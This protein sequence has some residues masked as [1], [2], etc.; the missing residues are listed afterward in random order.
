MAVSGIILVLYLIAHMIG[1]L[2]AFQ[3]EETFNHYS[4]W[5]R[6]IGDPAAAGPTALV[7][8]PARPAGRRVR[9]HVGRVLAVAPGQARPGRCA[10]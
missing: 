7:D 9:A 3:G 6:T 4:E 1:N 2:K 5:L 10:T 8:H